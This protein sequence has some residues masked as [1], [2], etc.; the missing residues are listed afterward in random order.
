MVLH[1]PV[2]LNKG[3]ATILGAAECTVQIFSPP[4]EGFVLIPKY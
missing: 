3:Q 1:R 4:I 2:E